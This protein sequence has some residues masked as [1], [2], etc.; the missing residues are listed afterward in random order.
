MFSALLQSPA[1]AGMIGLQE[2]ILLLSAG[3][4]IRT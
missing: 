2:T 1:L 3:Q 4:A